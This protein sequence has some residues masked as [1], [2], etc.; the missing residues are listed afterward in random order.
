[1]SIIAFASTPEPIESQ[2]VKKIETWIAKFLSE[3]WKEKAN[4][5]AFEYT[6]SLFPKQYSL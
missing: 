2:F 3:I 1:M 6:F 4:A 5:Y